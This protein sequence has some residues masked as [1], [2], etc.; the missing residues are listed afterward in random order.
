[1]LSVHL[2]PYAMHTANKIMI[3][4]PT[5][6]SDKSLQ[7]LFSGINVLPKI[8]HFHT[9]ACPTYILDNALQGLHYLP[10]WKE[11]AQL[12]VYL[13]PSPNHSRTVYLILN[14]MTGHVS[15]Q[16]HVKH[17]DFFE[18]VTGK[19]SNFDSPEPTWKKL[20]GLM[21]NNHKWSSSSGG[22]ATSPTPMNNTTRLD[23]LNDT[24][25]PQEYD[26]DQRETSLD[27]LSKTSPNHASHQ[28]ET[29]PHGSEGETA[30]DTTP[31]PSVTTRSG[32]NVQR[33]QQM[34][35]STQQREQGLVA[36]EVLYDQDDV[37]TK[38]TQ[39]DQFIL[40]GRLSN[41]IAFATSADPDIMYYHQAMKEPDHEQFKRSVLKEIHDHKT[42][43]TL[44][45]HTQTKHSP[46]HQALGYG[47]G[48]V[49][50]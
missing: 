46:K 26:Q 35:E 6:Y 10:K 7:E 49:Q 8:K 44:G 5:K 29:V 36:W 32:R 22:A 18:S 28:P 16:Y 34:E 31:N 30:M 24:N 50:E 12:G 17:D 3:S 42:K 45:S 33:T 19:S 47:M 38:P 13:G 15:P 20:S 9:F 43:P 41:P 14:P 23:D 40:Q 27:N 1:M 11:C 4:M 25:L 21:K 37:E 39:N 48:H 2:W